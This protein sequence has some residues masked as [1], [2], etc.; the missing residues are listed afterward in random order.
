M[1][2]RGRYI[3]FTAKHHDGFCLW[4]TKQTDWNIVDATPFGRDI[5]L[6][7][8]QAASAAGRVPRLLRSPRPPLVC[9]QARVCALARVCAQTAS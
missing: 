2:K 6:E 1:M 5:V 4:H 3:T 9:T 8:S 7:L